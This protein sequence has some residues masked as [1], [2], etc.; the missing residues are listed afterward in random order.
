MIHELK[1]MQEKVV[2]AYLNIPFQ[3]PLE[4][5]H[6]NPSQE[7]CFVN[8]SQVHCPCINPLG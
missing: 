4:T 3:Y 6:G 7:N 1:G 5:D 2:V 8:V